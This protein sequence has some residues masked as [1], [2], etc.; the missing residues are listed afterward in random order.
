MSSAWKA[1]RLFEDDRVALLRK[2]DSLEP[3]F[4]KLSASPTASPKVW[5]DAYLLAFAVQSHAQ[6]IT[7]DGAL[8]NRGA[9][10]IVLR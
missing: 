10:C 7:F 4:R 3:E 2:P 9:L 5:A 6:L 1:D 8:E